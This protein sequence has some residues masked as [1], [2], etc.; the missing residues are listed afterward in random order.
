MIDWGLNHVDEKWSP[1]ICFILVPGTILLLFSIKLI[2]GEICRECD[3][4]IR[5]GGGNQ[6][7]KIN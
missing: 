6:K 4:S 3:E 1:T 5:I 7:L 2:V